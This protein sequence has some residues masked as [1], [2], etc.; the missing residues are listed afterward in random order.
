M[1]SVKDAQ[2]TPY[3]A[4]KHSGVYGLQKFT[5]SATKRTTVCYSYFQPDGGAE[6]SSSPKERVYH[7]VRGSITVSGP[8]EKHVLNEGDCIY[9]APGEQRQMTINNGKPAEV[10]VFIVTP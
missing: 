4:A 9:I 5:E 7:V 10:L 6:M 2:G 1:I 8:D 3:D